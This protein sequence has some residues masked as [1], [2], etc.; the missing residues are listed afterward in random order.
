MEVPEPG[1]M[2]DFTNTEIAFSNKTNKE[3]KKM[4]FLFKWMNRPWFVKIGSFAGLIGI[5]LRFPFVK[6][7]VRRTIFEQFVGGETL[8]DC[9]TAI[10][11]L[12]RENALTILD[13]GA[14]GKTTEEE[15]NAVMMELTRAVD[16]A[17]SNSSVPVVSTKLTGLVDNDLLIKV[18]N[19]ESLSVGE[20]TRFDQFRERVDSIC[21]RAAELGVGV[22]IDAEESWLQQ[23]IDDL[24]DEL[25]AKYNQQKVIVYNTFQLYRHDRLQFLRDSF[26]KAKKEGYMLGAKLVRGAY[27]EKERE[28]AEKMGYP[29]PIH[30]DKQATDKD[31]DDAVRFCVDHYQ[32]VASCVATHNLE[33]SLLQARLIEEKGILKSHPHLNFCQ[34]YGMSDHITFNIAIQGFNVAKY[35]PYGHVREVLPYLIRRAKENSSVSGEISREYQLIKTEMKRRGIK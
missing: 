26:E 29:S 30:V 19:K 23:P 13:Y 25:M 11:K 4:A 20:Q 16:F 18:Q 2:I 3:L 5:K 35:V 15:L 14:E 17:A 7:I 28:R 6:T 31:F 10:D 21:A 8:L 24:A 9:Q 27:M 1:S 34:L 12:Y 32:E 33:S 22:F